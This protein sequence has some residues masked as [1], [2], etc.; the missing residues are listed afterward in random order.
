MRDEDLEADSYVLPSYNEGLP[1][2]IL[3]AMAAGTPIISTPVGGIPEAVIDGYN[4]YLVAPGDVD[5][6]FDRL[7]RLCEDAERRSVMGKHSRELVIRKFDM[8]NIVKQVSHVYD[9]LI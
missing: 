3:E 4:G 2:S 5:G 7:S 6:L 9:T 8:A 1:G